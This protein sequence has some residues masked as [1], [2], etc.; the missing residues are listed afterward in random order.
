MTR[1]ITREAA[2]DIPEFRRILPDAAAAGFAAIGAGTPAVE[3]TE[4]RTGSVHVEILGEAHRVTIDL[5][6]L[7]SRRLGALTLPATR[8]RI[9]LSGFAGDEDERFL[10]AFDDRYRKGGG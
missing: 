8:V 9:A 3:I 2:C 5:A 1:P 4:D 7:A 10:R 6:P